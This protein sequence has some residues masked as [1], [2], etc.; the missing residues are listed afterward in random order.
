[1]YKNVDAPQADALT[2][3][4]SFTFSNWNEMVHYDRERVP[5]YSVNKYISHIVE[6]NSNKNEI[7]FNQIDIPISQGETVDVRLKLIYDFGSPF[8]QTSSDWSDIVNVKFPDEYLKDVKVLDIIEEN[9]NDI[10]TNRFNNIMKEEGIPTH[11]GDKITDQDITYFHKPENIASGFYTAERRIIPLKDKLED[12][13]NSLIQLKDE[14]YGTNFEDLKISISQGTTTVQ[15]QPY[16][17]NQIYVE[18]YNTITS[19]DSTPEGHYSIV[20][21]PV[22]EEKQKLVV[23]VLNLS[24]YNDSNHTVKLFSMFPGSRSTQLNYLMNRKFN[25]ADYC[26]SDTLKDSS[27]P[28]GVWIEYLDNL[29]LQGGNQY[30]YFRINDVNTGHPFYGA[31][32]TAGSNLL[33]LDS[34]YVKCNVDKSLSNSSMYVYPKLSNQYDL[35]TGSNDIGT[36]RLLKSKEEIIIPIVVEYFIDSTIPT[37]SKTMSFD[38]LPSLYKDPINYTFKITAKADLTPQDRLIHN[39]DLILH[40]DSIKYNALI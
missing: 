23:T 15:L 26:D 13:N 19:N 21:V 35:C 34:T 18:S 37:L 27:L 12:L 31:G 20:G 11:I 17:T 4:D 30:L 16:E 7:S 39:R 1:M 5:V 6:D 14:I 28:G 24:L 22:G 40:T 38:I 2:F 3:N 25:K 10:E 33:S 36:H 29:F 32:D 9:N 8:V